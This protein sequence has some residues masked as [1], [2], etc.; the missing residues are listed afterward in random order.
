MLE[1]I[2]ITTLVI[3]VKHSIL[4]TGFHINTLEHMDLC[5]MNC[6]ELNFFILKK[7]YLSLFIYGHYKI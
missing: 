3:L 7:M 4:Y 2:I 5:K 1:K 6:L